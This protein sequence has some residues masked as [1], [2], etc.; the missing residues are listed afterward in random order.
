MR[1]LSSLFFACLIWLTTLGVSAQKNAGDLE[2]LDAIENEIRSITERMM[3]ASSP[4]S[5]LEQNTRLIEK[6]DKAL[7]MASSFDYP[8]DSIGP[9]TVVYSP[10]RFCRFLTWGLEDTEGKFVHFGFLQ[11]RDPN[12][13]EHH[14]IRL[15]DHYREIENPTY[16]KLGP[17]LWYGAIYYDI[18]VSGSKKDPRYTLLGWNGG[19]NLSSTKVI[20]VLYFNDN[21][22][23][24]FGAPL[25]HQEHNRKPFRLLFHYAEEANMAL[26]FEEEE[27]AIIYDH[28]SPPSPA[29]QDMKEYYVPDLSYDAYLLRNGEW[30]FESNY[31]AKSAKD[32]REKFYVTPEG[33]PF[34]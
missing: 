2:A 25:F 34:E 1:F 3:A 28:L 19:D 14:H 12:K 21:A 16:R 23:P 10:D 18:I 6:V 26:N 4:D 31:E 7:V 22:D 13:K 27:G 24:Y 15:E 30:H 29:Y 11:Y 32:G 8:F 5:A 17:D 33:N 20:D 9:I